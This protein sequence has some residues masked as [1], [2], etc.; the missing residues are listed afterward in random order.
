MEKTI[1]NPDLDL[2]HGQ[3]LEISAVLPRIA[4]EENSFTYQCSP[5]VKAAPFPA[6]Q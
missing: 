1:Q 6:A 4:A 3:I 5:A 2:K